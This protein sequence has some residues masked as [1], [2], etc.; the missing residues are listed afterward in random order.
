MT[1]QGYWI[2]GQL[3]V[4]VFF[5]QSFILLHETGH[6]SFFKGRGLNSFFGHFFG[7]LSVIPFSSWV[8][9]HN[10]HH[11]WTGWRDKDPTTTGTVNPNHGKAV[12]FI[13][14]ISWVLFFPIFTIGYRVGNYWNLKKI[15]Q[16]SPKTNLDYVLMNL[17]LIWMV[18]GVGL[19]LFW[20]EAIKYI[21]GGFVLGLAYSDLIILSQHSH[22][23][24]PVSKGKAVRPIKYINQIQYTRSISF[25]KLLDYWVLFNFNLHEKHHAFPGVPAYFLG[26]KEMDEPNKRPFLNYL[27]KAKLMT[28][29]QFIFST[30]KNSGKEI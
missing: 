30:S 26:K 9:I 20:D 19:F 15:K 11:K 4:G 23:D 22:I 17:L 29:E 5:L 24:I 10:Q 3:L 28:G 27:L 6:Y 25:F 7:F 14:N 8:D 18:W 16:F 21:I 1:H 12:R 13:V 2:L